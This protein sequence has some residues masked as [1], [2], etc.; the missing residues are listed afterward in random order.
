MFPIENARPIVDEL[1]F[2]T[3]RW[4]SMQYLW[5]SLFDYTVPLFWTMKLNGG[6]KQKQQ[7]FHNR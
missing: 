6:V 2:L 7:N 4:Y 3:C 5:H 1:S